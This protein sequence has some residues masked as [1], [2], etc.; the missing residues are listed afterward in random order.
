MPVRFQKK[1]PN[2]AHLLVWEV[3]ENESTLISLLPSTILTDAEYEEI[4]IPHKKIELLASRV[5]I[6]H[7]A[8]SLN[9]VFEGIKKDENGKPYLVNSHWH[10]SVTHSRHFMAVVMHPEKAVGIDIE[11]PQKKLQRILHRLFSAQEI[12]DMAGSLENMCIYWSA[13]EALYKLYGK[14]G[15]NF[16]DNLKVHKVAEGLLGEIIMPDHQETHQISIEKI[17]EYILVWAV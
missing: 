7:L 17:D 3:E 14:R 9:V 11:R 12:E 13:K 10:M 8:K 15:T 1:C 5:A 6:R 16:I 2:G 4:K